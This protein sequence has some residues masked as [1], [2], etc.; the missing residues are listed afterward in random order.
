MYYFLQHLKKAKNGQMDQPIYSCQTVSKRPNGNP[1]LS[2]H[3]F[4]QSK[5][6]F[7]NI[8]MQQ[9][10]GKPERTEENNEEKQYF[11]IFY[12]SLWKQRR[13]KSGK[14]LIESFDKLFFTG[15]NPIKRNFVFKKDPLSL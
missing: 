2:P 10:K 12:V 4:C 7:D 13:Q 9:K 5:K 14:L 6:F 3:K 8:I 15:G 11:S 1:A